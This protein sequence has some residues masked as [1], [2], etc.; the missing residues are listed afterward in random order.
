MM[1]AR[2]YPVRATAS[3]DRFALWR[4]VGT[5][6]GFDQGFARVVFRSTL[7]GRGIWEVG[8]VGTV[9]VPGGSFS[10]GKEAL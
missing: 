10:G 5:V 3:R 1:A 6:R 7:G 4:S 9:F 8:F 2:P